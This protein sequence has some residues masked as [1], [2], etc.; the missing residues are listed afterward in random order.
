MIPTPTREVR[1][2]L[3]RLRFQRYLTVSSL[4][5]TEK[6]HC[7]WCG[8]PC[9]G[10]RYRWCSKECNHEFLIRAG[11]PLYAIHKR[12]KGV[13]AACGIDCDWIEKWH[14]KIFSKVPLYHRFEGF[15]EQWGPWW[16]QHYAMW[17]AHHVLPVSQG[18]GC[19]GLDNYI[20]LCLRCHKDETAQLKREG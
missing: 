14:S 17:E 6:K 11:S 3:H 20:T 13:C 16:P 8:K 15:R 7:R 19:C 12:D 1:A 10:R 2:M 4:P 9:P 5:K 18:G